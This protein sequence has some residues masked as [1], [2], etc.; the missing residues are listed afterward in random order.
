MSLKSYCEK[1]GKEYLLRQW[2]GAKNLPMVPETVAH[3]SSIPVW[4]RCEKGH[5]WRTQVKSRA[6]TSTGCP[7]CLEVRLEQK[8]S[9][10]M[11]EAK[12]RTEKKEMANE[13][14]NT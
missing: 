3:S 14:E 2:D 5:S 11:A 12:K 6:T 10:Q 1:E 13:K 9:R 8:R 4:W 7:K